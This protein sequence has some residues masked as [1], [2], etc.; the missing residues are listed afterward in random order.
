M[1]GKNG[2]TFVSHNIFKWLFKMGCGDGARY[3]SICLI[4]HLV[5]QSPTCQ[6]KL[7][8][9]WIQIRYNHGLKFSLK[10]APVTSVFLLVL[11]LSREFGLHLFFKWQPFELFYICL[12]LYLCVYLYYI[13]LFWQQFLF[14]LQTSGPRWQIW[15]FFCLQTTCS[16]RIGFKKL[17]EI[18]NIK[19]Y[20]GP[21]GV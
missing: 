14:G 6:M 19:T 2:W 8:S 12:C 18:S 4:V 20:K 9:V 21:F 1:S 13:K 16:R 10:I 7:H 15:N 3:N 5:H 17:L 11:V